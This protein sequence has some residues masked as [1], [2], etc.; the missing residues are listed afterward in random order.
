[1]LAQTDRQLAAANDVRRGLAQR[2]GLTGLA[3]RRHFDE[4]R[5]QEFARSRRERLPLGL[6]MADVDHFESSNDRYGRLSG[7]D[8]LRRVSDAIDGVLLA[9]A[10][11]ARYRA[12]AAGRNCVCGAPAAAGEPA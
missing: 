3:N 9:M 4:L 7:D 8:C 2:D 11:Q 10:D 6:V 1:M 12:K 5:G